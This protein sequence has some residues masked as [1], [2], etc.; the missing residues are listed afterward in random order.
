MNHNLLNIVK[1]IVSEKGENV[2]ADSQ[3]LKPLFSD[4]A[5]DE[6]KEER[7]AFGRCVEMG[8]YWELKS[9]S[10]ADERRRKKTILAD[11]LHTKTGIEKEQCI[12]ALDLLEAVMFDEASTPSL[13]QISPSISGI[14][15]YN[16]PQINTP[17]KDFCTNCGT[18]LIAG[19]QFCNSCGSKAG[20]Q[21][22]I[23][24]NVSNQMGQYP[25]GY[26]PKNWM[27]TLLLCIFLPGIHRLYVGKIG[28]GL[29]MI[30]L[31]IAAIFTS[32]Y[33][34]LYDGSFAGYITWVPYY[35]WWLVDLVGICRGKFTDAQGFMLRKS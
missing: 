17:Q 7:I 19:S 33:F 6:P 23:V 18:Q 30:I 25:P 11:E 29:L 10:T 21:P 5:K 2:L 27:A 4:L 24:V 34:W 32:F 14:W 15:G 3:K 8:A 9:T 16:T 13:P 1:R 26:I 28:S 31:I 20:S 12:A 35:I 22:N